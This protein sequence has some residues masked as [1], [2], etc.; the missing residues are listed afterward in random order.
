MDESGTEPELSA[1]YRDLRKKLV[2]TGA[3]LHA[4]LTLSR[5]FE[6]DAA[7]KTAHDSTTLDLLLRVRMASPGGI[8]AVDLCEQM[9][10]SASHISRVVERAESAGLVVR[11]ADTTDRRAHK[12]DLTKRGERDL[13]EYIPHLIGVIDRVIFATLSSAEIETLSKLLSKVETTSRRLIAEHE[14]RRREK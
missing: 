4:H 10:K 12:I 8:R 9:Q 5:V 13:D 2:P 14:S 11:R 6:V 1:E 7:E 3:I